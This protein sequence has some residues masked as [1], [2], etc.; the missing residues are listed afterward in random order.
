MGCL[1]QFELPGLPRANLS[2]SLPFKGDNDSL[3]LGIGLY[4][5]SFASSDLHS[6]LP[7]QPPAPPSP[8]SRPPLALLLQWCRSIAPSQRRRGMRDKSKRPYFPHSAPLTM[9]DWIWGFSSSFSSF[10]FPC[11]PWRPLRITWNHNSLMTFSLLFKRREI[12]GLYS[13]DFL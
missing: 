1:L 13:F 3:L 10:S 9:P 5:L 11:L 6:P 2:I 7:F 4:F 12:F 8:V